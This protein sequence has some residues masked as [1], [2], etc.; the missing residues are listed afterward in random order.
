VNEEGLQCP[1]IWNCIYLESC[2]CDKFYFQNINITYILPLIIIIIII[3]I[4]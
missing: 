4:A 3:I 1:P 2:Y